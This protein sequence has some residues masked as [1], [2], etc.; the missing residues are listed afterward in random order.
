M[1]QRNSEE[2]AP[3][4]APE[5]EPTLG[6]RPHIARGVT[7][8]RNLE[9]LFI[10]GGWAWN[11]ERMATRT[12]LNYRHYWTS[13]VDWCE[14]NAL[15][16]LPAEQTTVLE[17]IKSRLDPSN[18][19]GAIRKKTAGIDRATSTLLH[20]RLTC[21]LT[22]IYEE[23][24]SVPEFAALTVEHCELAEVAGSAELYYRSKYDGK[25]R[26]RREFHCE[27]RGR[28]GEYSQYE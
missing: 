15:C 27:H 11:A 26:R 1:T 20:I 8:A 17:F 16:A 25:M 24:L 19:A 14:S 21:S 18:P 3:H 12:I 28:A 6:D 2:S 13:F 22:L 23:L 4:W 10:P 5:D 7:D 9:A